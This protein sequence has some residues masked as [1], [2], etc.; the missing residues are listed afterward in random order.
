MSKI[1]DSTTTVTGPALGFDDGVAVGTGR[2]GET[3]GPGEGIGVGGEVVG[4]SE[5]DCVGF[6][7]GFS[8]GLALGREDAVT[9]GKI[10]GD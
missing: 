6:S 2:V 10:D 3:V 7:D 8:D 1:L 4:D 5:G 9:V